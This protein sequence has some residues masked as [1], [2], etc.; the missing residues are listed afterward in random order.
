LILYCSEE[1]ARGLGGAGHDVTRR[2]AKQENEEDEADALDSARCRRRDE[3]S[4][5][6][7]FAVC[8]RI[9]LTCCS[10]AD[11][12]PVRTLTNTS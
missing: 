8:R 6:E 5:E 12:V 7:D 1:V 2:T 10:A 9:R 11:I 3:E 4:E